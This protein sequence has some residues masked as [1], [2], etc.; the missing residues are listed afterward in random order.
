M[1]RSLKSIEKSADLYYYK[2]K[3][4]LKFGYNTFRV[5]HL[6]VFFLFSV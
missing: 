3:R 5:K 1:C 4:H 2:T 6:K